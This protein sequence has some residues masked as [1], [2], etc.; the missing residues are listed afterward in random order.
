[1]HRNRR[2]GHAGGI[3]VKA[4]RG[5]RSQRLQPQCLRR[6][7]ENRAM[8][9]QSK[10]LQPH[11]CSSQLSRFISIDPAAPFCLVRA[12]SSVAVES[13][14]RSIMLMSSS[15]VRRASLETLGLHASNLQMR[16]GPWEGDAS[17]RLRTTARSRFSCRAVE[18]DRVQ[19]DPELLLLLYNGHFPPK[20]MLGKKA[21]RGELS[22]SPL[23]SKVFITVQPAW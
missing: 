20:N 4:T 6:Q 22:S 11:I 14:I 23:W 18:G 8:A 16:P 2:R 9:E 19:G 21:P 15:T 1:M 7:R 13:C 3:P 10:Q 17:K 5:L 12:R